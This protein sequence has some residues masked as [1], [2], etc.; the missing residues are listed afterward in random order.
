[1]GIGRRGSAEGGKKPAVFSCRHRGTGQGE[2]CVYGV[3]PGFPNNA[4]N[5]TIAG[6]SGTAVPEERCKPRGAP[7]RKGKVWGGIT[8]SK[9]SLGSFHPLQLNA[10]VGVPKQQQNPV[11]VGTAGIPN[12]AGAANS[13]GT[14]AERCGQC[15]PREVTPASRGRRL[16][17]VKL[18]RKN[19]LQE[20]TW[21]SPG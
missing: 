7:F 3:W 8:T 15:R 13:R 2:G 6:I 21:G 9:V 14:A 19:V 17:G 4:N 16:Q 18:P 11:S 20:G 1:M 12:S 10:S 5:L